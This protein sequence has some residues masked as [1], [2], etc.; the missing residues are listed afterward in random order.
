M[1][2]KLINNIK[3]EVY[4]I[5]KSDL[6]GHGMNH[7]NNVINLALEIANFTSSN[8]TIVYLIAL[9]HDVDDYKIVGMNNASL[10]SNAKRILNKYLNDEVLIQEVIK[11]ISEI[12]YSKRLDGIIPSSIEAKIVSDAD[13]LDAIGANGIIRSIEYNTSKGR[14]IFDE[15]IF[16]KLNM[17]SLEYKQ[18]N[19]S[20]MINHVFEKLLRLEGL[21]LTNKGKE[22]AKNRTKFMLDFLFQYFNELKLDSWIEYLNEYKKNQGL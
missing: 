11:G 18:K 14:K 3:N 17:N 16:P 9:L 7:I 6:S 8:K 19:D 22:L 10:L 12:G 5:L 4:E 2:N 1:D 21:M 13:M 15:N 20:T